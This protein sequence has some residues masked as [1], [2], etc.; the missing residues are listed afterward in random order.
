MSANNYARFCAVRYN[1]ALKAFNA[2]RDVDLVE[3]VCL[4]LVLNFEC[5]RLTQIRAWQLYSLCSEDYDEAKARLDSSLDLINSLEQ[6]DVII[7]CREKTEAMLEWLETHR[8]P[9]KESQ[10]EAAPQEQISVEKMDVDTPARTT[11]PLAP[12]SAGESATQAMEAAFSDVAQAEVLTVV[13]DKGISS[14]E[15]QVD[16]PP[17][18]TAPLAP[19]LARESATKDLA[20]EAVSAQAEAR[21]GVVPKEKIS[22]EDMVVVMPPGTTAPQAPVVAGGSTERSGRVRGL[23][24]QMEGLQLRPKP[25]PSGQYGL[26]P[27]STPST[28]RFGEK[29]AQKQQGGQQAPTPPDTPSAIRTHDAIEVPKLT[30]VPEEEEEEQ[31]QEQEEDEV[32]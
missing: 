21:H 17:V 31:E 5:P 24:Q 15:M 13:P 25:Q 14:E 18:V 16:V 12:S 28:T 3:D 20:Q 30:P 2:G 22:S 23:V 32:S 29:T 6:H 8:R 9:K 7:R 27:P 4:E 11:A 26:T 10:A 19:V 1:A